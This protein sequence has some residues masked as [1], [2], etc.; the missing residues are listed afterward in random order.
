M[1]QTLI[2]GKTRVLEKLSEITIVGHRV[3]HG[4]SEY[5]QATAITPAVKAVIARLVPI[6]PEHNPAALEGIEGIEQVLGQTPQVA[7]FDTAFHVA[8]PL[9]V[10]VY[11]IPYEWFEK[12]IRRYGFHGTSHRYCAH[13]TA[14]LLDKPLASLKLVTCHLGNGCSLVAIKNGIGIDTTMGFTPLEGLM[15][16]SR[17][18]SIDPA[19]LLYLQREHHLTID[20][21]SDMLNKHSGL[22]GVSGVSGDLRAILEASAQGNARAALAFDLFIHRLKS[23][24]GSMIASL[25][26]LDA[27][28]FTGGIGENSALVRERV[29]RGFEFLGLKLDLKRNASS[30][31]DG[32]LASPDSK[33]RVLAVHTQEHW[34]IAQECWH[35]AVQMRIS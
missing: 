7:V 17:S 10:K 24:V 2:E 34:A 8:M 20:Q 3:V 16:G 4:G 18:G 27:I 29:C 28:T 26:G 21:V 9:M 14:Q 19:I 30:T 12:G 6:A 15:M 5:S 33:V 13:R 22:K 11:P 1:L 35:Q 31:E 32:D 23:G 25:E